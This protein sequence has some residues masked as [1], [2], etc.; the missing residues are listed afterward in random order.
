MTVAF[1]SLDTLLFPETPSTS[2]PFTLRTFICKPIS[3]ALGRPEGCV[4]TRLPA[5]AWLP[6][7][8]GTRHGLVVLTLQR[9]S[10]RPFVMQLFSGLLAAGNLPK[11]FQL[12]L[13]HL[14]LLFQRLD[15]FLG[16]DAV[17]LDPLPNHLWLVQ[18]S[19]QEGQSLQ[20]N[21]FLHSLLF[22]P[23]RPRC[24]WVTK[25]TKGKP[26][27]APHTGASALVSTPPRVRKEI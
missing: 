3:K 7:N 17:S 16:A 4:R 23:A 5:D 19:L 24:K 14:L 22:A 25:D 13:H 12:I 10:A 1:K 18:A 26:S 27:T 15:D 6:L 20:T 2:T 9:L 11:E 8:E 21:P